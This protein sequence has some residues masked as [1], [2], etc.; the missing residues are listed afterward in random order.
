MGFSA[1]FLVKGR[2]WAAEPSELVVPPGYSVEQVAGAPDIRFPM[3]A[4]FDERGRL[5]V[6]ESSGLD[7][8]AELQKLSHTCRISVLED[9]DGDGRFETAHVFA[10][11]LVFP[12]GLC[13]HAGRLYVAD[14][15]NVVAFEDKDGDGHADGRTVI[16]GQFGH[17]DNGSLHGLI[18]GPDGWLYMTLGQPDGYRLTRS[19]GSILTGNSGALFRCRPDGSD[20]QVLCRGF[21]NLVEIEF[22]PGG[23]IIGTDNWFYVPSQGVRDALVHLLEGGLY[24]RYLQ[25][26]GTPMLVSGPPLPPISSYPAVAFSGIAR[27][28]G[29]AF[30]AEVR[31][32]IFSA[33]HNTRKVVQHHLTHSGATFQSADTDFVS[34]QNPDFHPSDVLED[35][36]GSLLVVDTGSW[37]IHHCPTGRIRHV[38]APGGIF[39]VRRSEAKLLADPRGLAL[40]WA[41]PSTQQLGERLTD[42]REAVRSR[43]VE[44]LV[45]RGTE[46][47]PTIVPLLEPGS[48]MAVL[49]K[50]V[51]TLSRIP[52]G[53]SSLG[54]LLHDANPDRV[55]LAARALGRAGDTN[56]T[57]HLLPLLRSSNAPVRL[58]AAEAL[59]HCGNRSAVPAIFD[60]LRDTEDPFVEHSLVNVLYRWATREDL[61]HALDGDNPHVQRAALVLL[62]QS[63][64]NALPAEAAVARLFAADA[65][66]RQAARASLVKHADW[67]D[68]AVPVLRKILYAPAAAP[69]DRAMINELVLAFHKSKSINRF[70]ADALSAAAVPTD[71]RIAL[72]DTL[73]HLPG[74]QVPTEWIQAL[75][76]L[77]HSSEVGVQLQAVRAARGLQLPALDAPLAEL[78]EDETQ[79]AENRVQAMAGFV[80][81][82]SSLNSSEVG[83]L[84]DRLEPNQGTS[85]RLEAAEILSQSQLTETDLRRF[86]RRA[87]ADPILSPVLVLA[88]AQR[89]LEPGKAA[90][91]LL[92]YL[93]RSV[94][95][96][97]TIS[98]EHLAWVDKTTPEADRPRV[99]QIRRLL[100]EREERQRTQLAE[101]EP[102]LAGG[103]P[104]RGQELFLR[105]ATCA[106]CHRVGQN[107]GQVG[108]DLTKI[109]AIRSGRDLLESVAAPSAT[110]AQGYE[111]YVVMLKNG[112]SI[113]GV[114]VRTNND[115]FVLRE[116]SGNEVRLDPAQI[117]SV[118]RSQV[119][120]MPEGLLSALNRDE[121]RDLL[122]YLQNLK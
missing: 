114:R 56:V 71:S 5:F 41:N 26:S 22:M 39:R 16:L 106:T 81:R 37:Y 11:G 68:N 64:H 15:P 29:T 90:D 40:D 55:A 99:Q 96:G 7:L 60:A 58:A 102:L 35:A 24:P 104:N 9:R 48:P 107:G 50:A 119:S 14:P 44:D 103:D 110:F 98:A 43:A 91:E 95:L 101:L 45:K 30:P 42:A 78:A 69:A 12:M 116:A 52:G 23:E 65:G 28:R 92:S 19:D 61:L 100:S 57:L 27:Y 105:K 73:A 97:G 94:E 122:A 1:L 77:L 74:P 51:W 82:R 63:P 93:G 80:R 79:P 54:P 53:S 84:F 120:I 32:D 49:E 20:V 8:Y 70:V 18:F 111:P 117:E 72:L 89:A 36:D 108:P 33:Q 118:Q 17:Q 83:V 31:G 62:D 121:V 112:D 3:F 113:N 21:E 4:T 87:Q 67:V 59:A 47:I 13:W 76:A 75:R 34:T 86:I 85:L 88:A 115:A 10:E 25:D 38:P 46:A 109:G 6:A 66:L 2:V